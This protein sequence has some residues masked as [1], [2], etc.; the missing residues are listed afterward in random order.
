MLRRASPSAF[1][2]KVDTSSDRSRES[3]DTSCSSA[4]VGSCHAGG[5]FSSS[6]WF[7]WR[8][9]WKNQRVQGTCRQQ[10]VHTF[11]PQFQFLMLAAQGVDHLRL[12][13][14][15]QYELDMQFFALT[16]SHMSPWVTRL[17]TR[18]GHWLI[19][20][21]R[22]VQH[23]MSHCGV[24]GWR[25]VKAKSW[26]CNFVSFLGPVQ[27]TYPNFSSEAGK[28]RWSHHLSQAHQPW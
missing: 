18:L 22:Q 11:P 7:S 6:H 19:R 26:T 4:V 8:W 1:L 9:P 28:T 20:K 12:H 21:I 23:D 16:K 14:Y 3:P 24:L 10:L 27:W 13:A 17:L 25:R 15:L 5:S 2:P